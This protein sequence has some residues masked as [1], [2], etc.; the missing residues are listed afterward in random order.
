MSEQNIRLWTTEDSSEHVFTLAQSATGRS[1]SIANRPWEPGDKKT[2]FR[3]PLHP[4]TGGLYVNRISTRTT[5]AKANADASNDGLLLHPPLVN[6]ITFEN[7]TSTTAITEFAGS[8]FALRE[9]YVYKIDPSDYSTAL[10]NTL[11]AAGVDMVVFNNE[12]F[13]AMGDGEK[14][15]SRDTGGTWTQ[16]TDDT[17]AIALGVVGTQLWR[18][19]T[20]NLISSCTSGPLTLASW[21]PASPNQY[22]AGD[23]THEISTIIDYGGI[24]W[25]GKPDGMYAPDPQTR[26][27]NQTPQ[28]KQWP[29]DG[30]TVGAFTGQGVLWVPSEPGLLRV[31]PGSSRPMGPELTARPDLR[32]AVKGGVEFGGVIYLLVNCLACGNGF[33]CK[34]LRNQREITPLE[35]IYHEWVRLGDGTGS[36]IAISTLPASPTIFVEVDD[37][38]KYVKLGRG[39]GRDIDDSQYE[40]GASMELETGI[41]VPGSDRTIVSQPVGVQVTL[42]YSRPGDSLTIYGRTHVH[43]D[44][45]YI[46]LLEDQ[47]NASTGPIEMTDDIESVRRYFPPGVAGQHVEVKFESNL[48]SASGTD[49]P[50]IYEAWLFGFL[51]P[52]KLDVITA[53][54]VTGT[55]SQSNGKTRG[56]ILDWFRRM[57]DRGEELILSLADY[58][59]YQTVRVVVDGVRDVEVF[60]TAANIGGGVEAESAIEVDFIRVDH[61]GGY[62]RG[63]S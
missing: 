25:V 54:I 18:A 47:E 48:D 4:W 32:F 63:N 5:Y 11:P 51:H 53:R 49:R 13:V 59:E 52:K 37:V 12:L 22:K 23:S 1:V 20:P 45:N 16:A 46:E 8:I 15:W 21:V 2:P 50:E 34:M 36:A 58:E 9:Q 17:F 31:Q 27:L 26:F 39:G 10:D 61:A 56:E 42:D 33:I 57:D 24:P 38:V 3:I 43:S 40:F 55:Y 7:G 28:I 6:E 29:D 14:I 35:Y 62:A 19:E 60:A 30:N 44:D 41:M